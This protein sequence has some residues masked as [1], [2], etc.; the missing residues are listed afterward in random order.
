MK[1]KSKAEYRLLSYTRDNP[2]T[3][4]DIL[5]TLNVTPLKVGWAVH[6]R[7]I[8]DNFV[9]NGLITKY[10]SKCFLTEEG[11]IELERYEKFY[12]SGNRGIIEHRHIG[13]T[14]KLAQ[15]N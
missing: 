12:P 8:Y 11:K 4:E 1:I 13:E 7:R 3:K 6:S 15:A 9:K 5:R 14:I 2:G 10:E